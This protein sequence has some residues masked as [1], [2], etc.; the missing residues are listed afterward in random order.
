M[1]TTHNVRVDNAR[2]TAET[3]KTDPSAAQ[4]KVELAGDWRVDADKPQFGGTVKFA[5]G[6]TLFEADFPPFLS[7][8]GR[9]PSPL[10]YCFWGALSCYASTF[11]M[12]AAMAG[13]GITALRSRL[14]LTVDFRGALGVANVVPL[15]TF[16]FEIEVETDASEADVARVKQLADERCPAIWAMDHEVPHT[17]EVHRL[18]RT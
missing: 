15:D 12:Q 16:R 14:R 11:A 9:A 13:I 10:I 5:K 17:T 6:E 2:Q 3:A 1:T 4:L 8:D 7:G 18:G